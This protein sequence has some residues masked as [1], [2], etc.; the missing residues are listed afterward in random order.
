MNP[1][2]RHVMITLLAFINIIMLPIRRHVMIYTTR[3]WRNKKAPNPNDEGLVCGVVFRC[4]YR[5][6]KSVR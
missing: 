6:S 2:R 5:I 4:L 1:I 3:I